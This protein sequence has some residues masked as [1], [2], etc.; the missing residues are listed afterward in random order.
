MKV[1]SYPIYQ[2]YEMLGRICHS[3]YSLLYPPQI[4]PFTN[5]PVIPAS[6]TPWWAI[7]LIT[8]QDF[9]QVLPIHPTASLKKPF[10]VPDSWQFWLTKRTP[11]H[12]WTSR[13]ELHSRAPADRKQLSWLTLLLLTWQID[14]AA[15]DMTHCNCCCWHDR[16]TLLWH[17]TDTA[18]AAETTFNL[19][20][21]HLQIFI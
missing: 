4:P 19:E 10:K 13:V 21:S 17:E 20:R 14:T 18:A 6:G 11:Y 12:L 2:Y 3:A 1:L 15:A 9:T 5:M 7:F 8:R 16:L